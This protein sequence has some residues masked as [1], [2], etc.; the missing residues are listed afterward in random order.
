MTAAQSI[1]AKI[2]FF[3]YNLLIFMKRAYLIYIV[4]LALVG[5]LFPTL[6]A[7][8][9]KLSLIPDDDKKVEDV[10]TDRLKKKLR[11]GAYFLLGIEDKIKKSRN[12]LKLLRSNITSL[13]R[14]IA[15]SDVKIE[16]LESQLGNFDR[17]I[18][19][20]EEKIH[21]GELQHAVY[22]NKIIVLEKEVVDLE[23]NLKEELE[24]L[25]TF[26]NAFYAQNNLFFDSRTSEPSL[27]AFLASDASSGEILRENE[28]L[29]FLKHTSHTLVADILLAQDT[30]DT[31]RETL[32]EKKQDLA[33][34]QLFLNREKRTLEEARISR[35]RLLKET[36]G[37]QAIYETLLE[38]SVKEQQQIAT[39][40]LRLKENFEFFQ[41]KLDEMKNN[42]DAFAPVET[43]ENG[44]EEL[45]RGDDEAL[46]W[47]VSPALGLSALF[48][49][50]SYRKALGVAH[51]AIDIRLTQGSKVRAA[52]DGVI[53][54]V[55]DNGFAYTYVIIAHPN[56]MLT[57]YGHL[58]EIL[59]EEGQIVRQG[60]V[61][62]LS[63]GIPGTKGAGWLTTGA[64]LH[65]EVFKNFVHVDP[66]DFLP[67]EFVP[68]ASLPEKY[69]KRL[70]P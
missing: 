60:Q 32:E 50:E 6:E 70:T 13:E 28:Y 10:L 16:D 67:L 29:Y 23:K 48:H 53:S 47:P 34:L 19:A 44:D 68:I 14:K 36:K 63:G 55:A 8:A 25:D 2:A 38:L 24:S 12:E 17:L 18:T 1:F 59:V 21:A 41:N 43:E 62:G 15:E 66:L 52:A 56:R 30:L 69:L 61:I 58:S 22:E 5:V 35:E 64:H 45:L 46:A 37:K 57:L 3:W 7:N 40:I 54:K 20:N 33:D 49:D 27:L 51:N 39:E 31:K 65:F 9:N 26:F 42:P 11:E 4:S